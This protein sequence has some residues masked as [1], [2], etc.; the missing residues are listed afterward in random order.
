M[1]RA[2]TVYLV[3]VKPCDR[4]WIPAVEVN[5]KHFQPPMPLL[6]LITH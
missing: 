4:S 5:V 6:V 3:L 1:L 2:D